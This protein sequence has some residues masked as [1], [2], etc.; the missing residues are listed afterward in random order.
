MNSL[1]ITN[2]LLISLVLI[3]VSGPALADTCADLKAAYEMF[4][5]KRLNRCESAE[6]D[7]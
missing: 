6:C 5:M 7:R 4:C 1:L 2:G 3:I